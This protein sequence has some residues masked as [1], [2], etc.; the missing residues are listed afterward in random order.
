[1][2]GPRSK[3]GFFYISHST[4]SPSGED[5]AR[6]ISRLGVMHYFSHP[7]SSPALH[8]DMTYTCIDITKST[9]YS[10]LYLILVIGNLALNLTTRSYTTISGILTLILFSIFNIIQPN[11]FLLMES[12]VV[13]ITVTFYFKQT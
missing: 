5:I 4:A 8:R 1:M 3:L 13:I 7:P 2:W 11:L 10:V 6:I 9:M 12:G